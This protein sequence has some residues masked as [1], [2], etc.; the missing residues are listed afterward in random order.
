VID[1][2]RGFHEYNP[3]GVMKFAMETSSA[4]AWERS[5]WIAGLGLLLAGGLLLRSAFRLQGHF[6][7]EHYRPV[8]ARKNER[9]TPVGERPLAWWAVKRVSR[10]SGRINLY[11]AGGFGVV[12]A[13]YVVY[14]PVWPAWLGRQ[15]F[16]IFEGVGGLPMLATALVLLASVPAAFQY[17]LWDSNDQDRCRRLELLL[18][19]RLDG[20]AYWEAAATAAWRRGRGYFAV[21]GLLWAAALIS[22]RASWEQVFAGVAAGVVLWG[23]YFAAGFR[24]FSRGVQ[25]GNLGM[26]LTLLVPLA[27]FLAAQAGWPGLALLLPPGS[28]YFGTTQAPG[29]A[30][31]IGPLLAGAVALYLARQSLRQC[32]ADLRRWLDHHGGSV[33]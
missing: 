9:R 1:L 11:L 21:A 22:G 14:E 10:Y 27:A 26:V 2:V 33:S 24:A 25:A 20:A 19:T 7:D 4:W 12:Y 31:L 32:E 18:L 15:V 23:L 5:C 29:L 28:I 13:A 30:W 8:I 16:L 6:Q 17:G 3:F